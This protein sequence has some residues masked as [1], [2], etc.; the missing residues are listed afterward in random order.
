MKR[1]KIHNNIY[2]GLCALI[3]FFLPVYIFIIPFL[4]IL[5]FLNW[6]IEGKYSEKILS[7]KS[8]YLIL[9]ISYYLLYFIGMLWTNNLNS[10]WFD[11]EVKLPFL[12]FPLMAGRIGQ[13]FD[14]SKT[15]KVLFVYVAGS[16]VAT[17]ICLFHAGYLWFHDSENYFFYAK[18]SVFLHP[19]YLSMYILLAITL[20]VW[21]FYINVE[22]NKRKLLIF[23]LICWFWFFIILLQSKAGIIIAALMFLVYSVMLIV[24]TKKYFQIISAFT[25]IF[26][27][28]FIINHFAITANISRLKNAKDII[29]SNKIDTATVE[30]NQARILVWKASAEIIKR[31]YIYGVGTGDIKD[32]LDK[33][34]IKMNMTG[35]FKEH[36]NAHN[37]YL[38]SAIGLGVGGLIVIILMF[39]LPL[40][41]SIK[42]KKKIYMFFLLI[43][44]LNLLVESMFETQAGVMFYAFF[45]ILFF[46]KGKNSE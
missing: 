31:N 34:Y 26:L 8:K 5:I 43:V 25:I 22:I 29:L 17:L 24:K 33:M 32:E 30:S 6:I 19:S 27:G 7:L 14:V 15:T 42:Q 44:G 40:I 46:I 38:Q 3:A 9:F 1:Q 21:R 13:I 11:L 12:I 39:L 28:Y 35:I 16:F 41:Y 36:L 37:Q 10:G 2:F 23:F 4:I 18:L 45:N 20:L